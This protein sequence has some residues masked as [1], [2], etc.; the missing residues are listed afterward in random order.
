MKK[1]FEEIVHQMDI[2]ELV[3]MRKDIDDGGA[4]IKSLI[5]HKI[6]EELRKQQIFCTTCTGK[7]S[8]SS[9]N[10]FTLIFGPES[11][12]RKAS[13]CGMDCMEYFLRNLKEMMACRNEPAD[14]LPDLNDD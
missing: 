1:K 5:D 2:S 12:K 6:K 7:V 13:F 3:R 4:G 10:N 11:L 14:H 8:P 9:E